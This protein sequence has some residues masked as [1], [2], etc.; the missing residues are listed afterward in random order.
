LLFH[1]SIELSLEQYSILLDHFL[2]EKLLL[3]VPSQVIEVVLK[4]PGEFGVYL[5]RAHN[6]DLRLRLC[7]W[8][9]LLFLLNNVCQVLV[10]N[11]FIFFFL[12]YIGLF[13]HLL[14]CFRFFLVLLFDNRYH[15]LLFY[16]YVLVHH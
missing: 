1:E 2:I 13:L 11:L 15:Y 9:K 14:L 16:L 5:K 3:K 10:Q 7:F 8:L 6:V 12:F 4:D